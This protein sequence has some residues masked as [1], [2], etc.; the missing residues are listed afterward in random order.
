MR[1]SISLPFPVLEAA[2]IPGLMVPHSS[3]FC[4]CP[5]I[6]SDSHQSPPSDYTGPPC[7][8]RIMALSI[9]LVTTHAKSPFCHVR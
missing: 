1:E 8:S 5:C 7:P 2:Y 3:D 9:F 6:S 4:I